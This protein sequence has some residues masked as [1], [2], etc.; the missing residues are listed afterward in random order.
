MPQAFSAR[1]L[2]PNSDDRKQM[3]ASL[4]LESIDQLI[5]QTVP[6]SLPRVSD[7]NIS[8]ALSEEQAL[9][10]LSDLA[11]QNTLN[12]SMIGCG[13]HGTRLPAVIRRNVLENPDWYTAYTPY[14]PEISQ[15][16]LEALMIFQQMIMDLTGMEIANASLLD[17][18]TAAAEAMT[19][20]KRLSKNR[21]SMSY[22][23]DENAHPQTLS[24]MQTRAEP[25]GI[26]LIIGHPETD[27]S[28][29]DIF[30]ALFQYPAS[31]G[32]IKDFSAQIKA[33]QAQKGL[34]TLAADI[35]AL[36][37][38]KSPAELGADIAIGST[39]R[40]GVPMG[41]G[42]PHAAYFATQDAHKRSVPG[43]LIGLSIDT[44]GNPAYRMALQTREQHI[45]REKA[46]SNICTSQ[47]LLA[48]IAALYCVYHGADGVKRIAVRINLLTRQLADKLK[49]IKLE[50]VHQDYFDT[51]LINVP[52]QAKKALTA[53]L[54]HGVNIRFI[55]DDHISITLDETHD[56]THINQLVN[57]F[58][59]PF[60]STADIVNN[61]TPAPSLPKALIRSSD[62]FIHP[63]FNQHRNETSMMRFL[64][65][66]ARK[67]I[68]L[69]RSM[70]P[71]G[72]CTMKLNSATEMDSVSNPK[73]ASLHPFVPL[74][75]A[76][77]YQRIIQDLCDDLCEITGYDAVSMQPNA[78][79]QGEFA[80]L[81]SIRAYHQ[82]R[83]DMQRKVC[84]IPSSAHGTNPA[85]AVMAGMKVIIVKCDDE[86]NIDLS[87]LTEKV[88]KHSAE[89][90]ALMI[91]YP[92][93]YG[94]FEA[95][96]QEICQL[97][98]NHGGQV[99]LDG[100]NL[101][102]MI[103]IIRPGDLGADVS[104]LN[105]HKT[106]AIP[107]GGGG[108]GMGP[109][110][111]KQHLAAFLP[112]HSMVKGVNPH[113]N[114]QPLG[115]VSAAPWG[116]PLILTISWAYIKMLG[117]KGLSEATRVAIL[118]SNYIAT[119]LSEHYPVRYTSAQGRVA[120]ECIIDC[121]AFK[122]T[123]GVMVED[124]AKRLMD[125]GFHSPT[126]SWP[127][128]DS[129]MIE[130]TESEP[131][132]ELDRFIN[133]MVSIR[134]EIAAIE[135]GEMDKDN[136]P[137][138]NAPHS[139]QLIDY[140]EWPFPY[141]RAQAFFPEAGSKFNKYWPPVGRID[142]IYGDKNLHC[143]CPAIESYAQDD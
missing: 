17:E 51:L 29:L 87:D 98:H 33:V 90:A 50:I 25:M 86:G 1:H 30:G 13:Y 79:S 32:E 104:H 64:R 60:R 54:A 135:A 7:P 97:I 131:K 115:S 83:G 102:A 125:Y 140:D 96:V 8:A 22:F 77:G 94:V 49:Q 95:T 48:I 16:R 143:S 130:P 36:T 67:D 110:G 43:R 31:T 24:V 127:V 70:I 6:D 109:I 129:L 85:S 66:L 106:F 118:S 37:L 72:S 52:G 114:A 124:I 42:G 76:K 55:D 132:A 80:G 82:S 62:Y 111:V 68:T 100:A 120:H 126:M 75:Q 122:D 10:T 21:T 5:D 63:V 40:F 138:K 56:E 11:D 139:N 99:Y 92:S 78:G 20:S 59:S 93:T 4:G 23:V 89:L 27:L 137:L 105:L 136:N 88:E 34:A 58:A 101:N 112:D 142:N 26:E 18:A 65:G 117:G 41:Y 134:K 121:S 71:L 116:S 45:R 46:T 113:E 141:T 3:L 123:C 2:G 84:L 39:Q 38:I 73:F 14:Q 47:A 133:A 15:G 69:A 28:G 81:L 12:I 103:G 53:A 19:M 128:H 119:A 9:K 44:Q 74:N 61:Q 108:P 91:T 57:A 35:M 107:H